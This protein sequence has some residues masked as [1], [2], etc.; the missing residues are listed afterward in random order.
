[1]SARPAMSHDPQGGAAR[2]DQVDDRL[3]D[4]GALLIAE[5]EPALGRRSPP[6]VDA[7]TVVAAAGAVSLG[8]VRLSPTPGR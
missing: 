3:G 2:R 7:P 8:T 1:M 5:V 4:G 6:G